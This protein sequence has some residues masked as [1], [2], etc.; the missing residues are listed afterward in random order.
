VNV[1]QA[2]MIS[3]PPKQVFW[4]LLSMIGLTLVMGLGLSM[5]V[6]HGVKLMEQ[7]AVDFL[8]GGQLTDETSQP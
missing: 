1:P 6:N 7:Q 3:P 8:P 4:G 2:K 5:A